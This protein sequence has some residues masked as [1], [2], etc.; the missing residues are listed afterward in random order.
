MKKILSVLSVVAIALSVVGCRE[1]STDIIPLING[2]TFNGDVTYYNEY[3]E[4]L[5]AVLKNGNM[6]IEVTSPDTI[7]GMSLEFIDEQIILKYNGQEQTYNSSSMPQGMAFTYIYDIFRDISGGNN[8]VTENNDNYFISGTT[9]ECDY[10]LYVGATGLPI[11]IEEFKNGLT[12]NFKNVT[13]IN[14]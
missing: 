10:K 3:C 13:L 4:C 2:I 6:N 7:K 11:K 12:V 5:V 8:T 14:E 9:K 1:K